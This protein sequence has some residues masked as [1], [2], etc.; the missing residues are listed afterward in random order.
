[1]KD[2]REVL[3]AK[4]H[5]ILKVKKEIEALRIAAELLADQPPTTREKV[6]LRQIIEMP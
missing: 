3:R 6:D 1:M 4:E 5:Q 2:P